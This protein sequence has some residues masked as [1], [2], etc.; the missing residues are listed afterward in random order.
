MLGQAQRPLIWAGGGVIAAGA[1]EALRRLAERIGGG[2]ITTASGRGSLP[3]DDRH[4]I[5]FFANDQAVADLCA[6]ADLLLAVGTRFRGTDTRNWQLALPA[7]KVQI[8]VDPSML[9]RN[10]PVDVALVGDARLA[11]EGLTTAVEARADREWL[12]RV[13]A[14]RESARERVRAGLGRYA[15]VVDALRARL[16]RDAIVVRDVTIPASTWGS[17]LLETYTPRTTLHSATVAIGLGLGLAIGAAVGRPDRDVVLLVGDGGLAL[18]LAEL[19]TAA[20]CGARIRIVVF[21]DN[22]YGILRR[23]QDSRFDGR[24]FGVDLR[25]PDYVQLGDAMGIWAAQVRSPV[26][27]GPQLDEAMLQDGP[28]LIEVVD[29]LVRP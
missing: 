5:G 12:T 21:N 3:E 24:H 8:D 28:S 7:Y 27:M 20:E 1:S 4:C 23:V 26:E 15:P 14:A 6:E 18:G 25:T 17:R 13:G 2:V 9:G 29:G 22:G 11:L 19:I 16:P 10:Y